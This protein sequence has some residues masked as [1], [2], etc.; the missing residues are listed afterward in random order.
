MWK[1]L[2]QNYKTIQININHLWSIK[3]VNVW[4]KS[5]GG[6]VNVVR[7]QFE[8]SYNTRSFS[9]FSM[10][11]RRNGS[12]QDVDIRVESKYRFTLPIAN[13]AL[14]RNGVKMNRGFAI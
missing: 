2:N 7:H 10:T 3:T 1:E 11:L 4:V 14:M 13:R 12:I 9:L 6:R 5:T 8:F